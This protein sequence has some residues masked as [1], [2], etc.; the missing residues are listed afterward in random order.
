MG[1]RQN[2][3]VVFIASCGHS[4]STIL[5]FLLTSDP[6]C[7]GI[8]EAFQLVDPRNQILNHVHRYQCA[9]GESIALCDFWGPV[10]ENLKHQQDKLPEDKYHDILEH[11]FHTIGPGATIID[12]SKVTRAL[13]VLSRLA[14]TDVK[15]IH[16]IRDV[17]SYCLSIIEAYRRNSDSSSPGS[18]RNIRPGGLAQ[19]LKRNACY[20]FWDWYRTNL[21]ISSTVERLNLPTS[22]VSYEEFCLHTASVLDSLNRFLD[23]KNPSTS[24]G[25]RR[26]Q[27]SQRVRQ[28]APSRS[29]QTENHPIRFQ[30]DWSKRLDAAVNSAAPRNGL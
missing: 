21:R 14:D 5:E 11:A 9:C 3:Q 13:D 7:I 8:G 17:R 4:G 1:H 16:L 30:M 19:F 25:C 6:S 2:K 10:I 29:P 18:G 12:S 28:S 26:N 27:K 15:V 20:I 22:T 24:N 23:L